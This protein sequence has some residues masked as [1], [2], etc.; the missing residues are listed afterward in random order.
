MKPI[1]SR[2][3]FTLSFFTNNSHHFSFFSTLT[4]YQNPVSNYSQRRHQEESRTVRVSVWW[5]FENCN[6]PINVN[7]FR[8]SQCITNAIRANGIKGP[9]QITAFGDV[10]QI[11]RTNQEALSSTGISLTHVPSGGKNSADRSLLV[12]LMYWVSQNPPP[13]H[14]FLISGDRDFAGI[15]HRLR[16]NNYNILLASPD[17]APS[18]LCSAATIMWQWSS[19]LKG[20]NLTGKFFNQP[21]DGLYNSWY[22]H[23]K[24]PLEDPFA[25]NEQSSYLPATND[26][27]E[28]AP[29]SRLRPIPKAVMNHIGHIL[30]SYPEGIPL[31]QLRVEIW[32]SNFTID[33]DLYGYKKFSRFLS[34]MP[35]VLKLYVGDDGQFLARG[36]NHK[37]ESVSSIYV[38]PVKVGSVSRPN[39]EIGSSDNVN[40]KSIVAQVPESRMKSQGINLQHAPK[41]EKV[42]ESSPSMYIQETKLKANA[43]KVNAQQEERV[44][45][46]SP[47][48]NMDKV[49]MKAYEPKQG[50]KLKVSA[51]K[52]NIEE[53][54]EQ[55]N[56]V[57]FQEQQK[58][59]EAVSPSE[60]KDFSVK[61]DHRLFAKNDH[62]GILRMI[63]MKLFG[64]GDTNSTEKNCHKLDEISNSIEDKNVISSQ[65]AEIM[66]PALFSPSSHEA[67]ILGKMDRDS[68]IVITEISSEDSSFFD[69][70]MR[71]C[72]IWSSPESDD[73]VEKN[74]EKVDERKITPEQI[75]LFSKD[76][77]W[78]ELELFIGT[79]Q[80]SAL[81]LQSRTRK[82]LAQNLRRKGHSALRFLPLCDLLHL[83]DLLISDKKWVEECDSET[84]PFKLTRLVKKD[85][86]NDTP[87]SSNGLSHMF[88]NKQPILQELGDKKHR[89]PPHTGVHQTRKGS[90]IKSNSEILKD[91]E[92]LVDHIVNNYPEGFN[93]GEFRRLFIDRYGY[94][95]DLQKI[96][97]D[98]LVNL[99][100]IMPGAKIDH[101]MIFPAE[102][103]KNIG[104]Q[105]IQESES[106]DNTSSKDDDSD[107]WDELGPVD[108]KGETGS[109]FFKKGQ[110]GIT[111]PDYEP[112]HD[113]DLSDSDE[114]EDS[115]SSS[116][117]SRNEFEST[118]RDSTLIQILDSWY[119]ESDSNQ[120]EEPVSAPS[121]VR[122]Q[123]PVKSYTFVAEHSKDKLI[124]DILGSM[125]KSGE[126]LSEK[127]EHGGSDVT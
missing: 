33:K 15:L 74:C 43:P 93:M 116:I 121:S 27:S 117:R 40:E 75:E 104:L 18:V 12:D 60:I 81:I 47:A 82:H 50:E 10:M 110:K 108:N 80:G 76:S 7:V 79:S 119:Q 24:G 84:S 78:N 8:V 105:T 69:R 68:D 66:G 127:V 13:A 20:E 115:S 92:K 89:N 61:N 46:S 54:Q 122:K 96:G 123:K 44:N 118:K 56:N 64:S 95:L 97:F 37:D 94:A 3:I 41:E 107:S 52:L 1:S 19:L 126:R 114:D 87:L 4:Q 21:P 42:N 124:D 22:G 55:N 28:L 112:V 67:L 59:V 53:L 38:E 23:P 32:K 109:G 99:L 48:T 73:K 91:C 9:I 14:L 125:K 86:C 36:V 31:P 65:S 57:E 6:L 70:M 58:K 11:S 25:I 90:L 88:S 102:S 101:N 71:R 2:P 49:K 63:W 98:K 113:N 39:N 103:F 29:D 85:P 16:M 30:N 62:T 51:Q 111:E 35:Q 5:D 45:E 34:A 26:S 72:K 77:F 106:S 100:Q 83:V 120:K 17:S